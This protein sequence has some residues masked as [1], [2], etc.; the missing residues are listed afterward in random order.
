MV[1]EPIFSADRPCDRSTLAPY[2]ERVRALVSPKRWDHIERV[3][4]LAESIAQA[5]QFPQDEV[6]A[7]AL[8][9]ILHDAARELSDEELLDLA[10]PHSKEEREHPMTLHGRAARALAERWGVQDLRV[11]DA[12][13]GHVFGVTPED[14]IGMAVYIADMSEPGRG[15]NDEIRALAMTDLSSAYEK[16]VRTKVAYLRERGKPI[17]PITLEVHEQLA[18]DSR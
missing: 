4:I 5:N 17:H 1:S 12:I 11:L 7:A 18:T 16:A 15:V 13:E 2:C 3:A 6:D 8:A 14:R 9:G 10:P